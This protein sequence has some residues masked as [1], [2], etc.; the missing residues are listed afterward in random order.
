VK[1]VIDAVRGETRPS[2]EAIKATAGRLLLDIFV[3]V[4]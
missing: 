2:A 4:R 3:W 1:V